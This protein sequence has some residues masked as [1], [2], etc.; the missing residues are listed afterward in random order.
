MLTLTVVPPLYDISALLYTRSIPSDMNKLFSAAA[1]ASLLACVLAVADNSSGMTPEQYCFPRFGGPFPDEGGMWPSVT[2][3]YK[4]VTVEATAFAAVACRTVSNG[5]AIVS[6]VTGSPPGP[7]GAPSGGLPGSSMSSNVL[8]VSGSLGVSSSALGSVDAGPETQSAGAGVSVSTLN[9]LPGNSAISNVGSN[10]SQ[11]PTTIVVQV[12]GT[13]R[14]NA[15]MS[16]SANVAISGLLSSNSGSEVAL[17]R[18][19]SS[20]DTPLVSGTPT[21]SSGL[22]GSSFV[23]VS[24]SNGTPLPSAASTSS[25]GLGNMPLASGAPQ[26]GTSASDGRPTDGSGSRSLVPSSLS[27]IAVGSSSP[28]G[29]ADEQPK[30]TASTDAS[31]PTKLPGTQIS[32]GSIA[33]ISLSPGAVDALQLAQFLKNL[34]VSAFNTSGLTNKKDATTPLVASVVANISMVRIL[35]NGRRTECMLTSAIIARAQPAQSTCRYPQ[36][37]RKCRHSTLPIHSPYQCD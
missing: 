9:G 23:S 36:P 18:S 17:T 33:A 27:P 20:N 35:M 14:P 37:L 15:G 1:G 4:G 2:M 24:G 34:G 26:A 22:G 32:N 12:S 6:M 10:V 21:S 28:P 5:G 7:S 11:S 30:S 16:S 25:N 29:S 13:P 31:A 3:I 8:S 19:S